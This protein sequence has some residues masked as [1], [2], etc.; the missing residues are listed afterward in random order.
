MRHLVYIN[1]IYFSLNQFSICNQSPTATVTLTPSQTSLPPQSDSH[2]TLWA[3]PPGIRPFCPCGLW[4]YKTGWPFSQKSYWICR[5]TRHQNPVSPFQRA[6]FSVWAEPS[7]F[8]HVMFTF[9]GSDTHNWTLNLVE[10]KFSIVLSFSRCQ[11]NA[12]HFRKISVNPLAMCN[13]NPFC[14]LISLLIIL[15]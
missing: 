11:N 12:A 9:S 15:Q 4:S 7:L 14:L 8:L 3:S 10:M 6:P 1:L 13:K 2:V 5:F